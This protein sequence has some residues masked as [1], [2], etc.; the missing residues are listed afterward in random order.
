MPVGAVAFAPSAVDLA[1]IVRP[2]AET[3][4]FQSVTGCCV[5]CD[6]RT[7]E[8]IIRVIESADNQP[9]D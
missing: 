2:S 5:R 6:Y 8:F 3:P 7:L 1:V 9:A 4:P